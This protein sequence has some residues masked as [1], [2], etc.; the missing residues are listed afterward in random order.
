MS[1]SKSIQK[2]LNKLTASYKG[3][4]VGDTIKNINTKCLHY[5]SVG[6]VVKIESLPNNSGYLIH[7]KVENFGNTYKN[8][9]VLVKTED[10]LEK[11]L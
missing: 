10:Q 3:F 2:L 9:D 1:L 5:G 11:V 8:G 7:Y 4:M 6:K